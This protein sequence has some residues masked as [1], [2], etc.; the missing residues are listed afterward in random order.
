MNLYVKVLKAKD[1][2]NKALQDIIKSYEIFTNIQMR[3]YGIK[4]IESC[5]SDVMWTIYNLVMNYKT[6]KVDNNLLR[7]AQRS[8]LR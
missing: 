3:R 1:G 5:Y 8:K 2:D 7:I 6:I 4:D